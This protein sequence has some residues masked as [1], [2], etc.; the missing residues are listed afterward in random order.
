MSAV[1]ARQEDENVTG[2]R[3]SPHAIRVFLGLRAKATRKGNF[4]VLTTNVGDHIRDVV[5]L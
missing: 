1:D 2:N 3:T 4:F 5:H